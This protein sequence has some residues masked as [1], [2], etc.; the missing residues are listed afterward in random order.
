[1]IEKASIGVDK[2]KWITSPLPRHIV[3]VSTVDRRKTPNVAPKSWVSMAAL[4]SAVIGFGCNLKHQKQETYL[5][6][7]NSSLTFQER[8]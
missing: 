5:K 7:E 2:T 4:K 8:T 6:P 3:P 1:M